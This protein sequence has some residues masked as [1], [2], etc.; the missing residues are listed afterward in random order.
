MQELEKKYLSKDKKEVVLPL[1][2]WKK[3]VDYI[4]ELKGA[5]ARLNKQIERY[6]KQFTKDN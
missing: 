6:N 2:E 4:Q 3:L 5:N 1:S